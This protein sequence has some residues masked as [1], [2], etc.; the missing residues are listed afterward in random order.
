MKLQ[1][2]II[3][4]FALFIFA[5]TAN[6]QFGDLIN[7]A[8]SKVD[9]ATQKADK[10]K[11][12]TN[13]TT[14]QTTGDDNTQV[15]PRKTALNDDDL[16]WSSFK[17][18][19]EFT[20]T[21]NEANLRRMVQYNVNNDY[22]KGGLIVFTKQPLAKK[23]ATIEDSVMTFKAGE[24]IYMNI[25][26]KEPRQLD[27]YGT[28]LRI[29]SEVIMTV[30][31]TKQCED[32]NYPHSLFV[33]YGRFAQ[34]PAALDFQPQGGKSAKYQQ[35]IKSITEQLRALPPGVHIV[36]VRLDGIPAVGA[37]YYDNRDGKANDEAIKTAIAEVKMPAPAVRMPALEKQIIANWNSDA[38]SVALRVVLIDRDWSPLRNELGAIR[39]RYITAVMAKKENGRCFQITQLWAQNYTGS[40][41]TGLYVEGSRGGEEMACENVMK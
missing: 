41:Y 6:A 31:D 4:V 3:A 17:C 40:G 30:G 27:G 33:D 2:S 18:V 28:F 15:S 13:Q 24:P 10:N 26:L 8:K 19:P 37:F 12:K 5:V 36:P 34:I 9:K 21:V 38:G 23:N 39:G 11:P 1:K 35:Q 25:V 7:K 16:R 29:P 20:G 14:Q 22:G 32:G